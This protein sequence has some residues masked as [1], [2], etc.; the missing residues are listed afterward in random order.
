M[1]NSVWFKSLSRA[2]RYSTSKGSLNT[3]QLFT[4]NYEVLKQ[5]YINLQKSA[6]QFVGIETLDGDTIT[7]DEVLVKIK[8]VKKIYQYRTQLEAKSLQEK[9]NRV[10]AEKLLKEA[11]VKELKEMIKGKTSA[12]IRE[13]VKK[14][15][16]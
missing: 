15:L 12:Q 3:E 11:D 16:S 14:L 10:L 1:F 13:E 5:L 7:N 2:Y 6:Q 9:G 8:L 4:V